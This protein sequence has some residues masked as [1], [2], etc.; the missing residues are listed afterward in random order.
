MRSNGMG[1][2][3][4][5]SAGS[6]R[7]LN[8]S[9]DSVRSGTSRAGF[10]SSSDS[11]LTDDFGSGGDVRRG[12]SFIGATP[13]SA[14]SAL[15]R[16]SPK[17]T[18]GSGAS[19]SRGV[20]NRP[21]AK[22]AANSHAL[23]TKELEELDSVTW[24]LAQRVDVVLSQAASAL[25]TAFCANLEVALNAHHNNSVHREKRQPSDDAEG[26]S[27]NSVGD[28]AS[29]NQTEVG[30]LPRQLANL[31][32]PD[33]SIRTIADMVASLAAAK[34]AKATAPA[35]ASSPAQRTPPHKLQPSTPYLQNL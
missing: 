26:T 23:V 32:R 3:R 14:L 7:V 16:P 24:E 28:G 34:A 25:V 10:N 2:S 27:V 21:S 15:S 31:A 33:G 9:Q 18:P 8:S 6:W 17:N 19:G 13:S 29:R 22:S 30:N 20:G 4:D 35:V 11:V 12:G 1:H 5:K